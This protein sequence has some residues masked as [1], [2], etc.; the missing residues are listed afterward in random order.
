VLVCPCRYRGTRA[1]HARLAARF[2]RGHSQSGAQSAPR[3]PSLCLA[4][5]QSMRTSLGG[6]HCMQDVMRVWRSH[7]LPERSRL[8]S[9][10]GES[11]VQGAQRQ[12]S[13]KRSKWRHGPARLRR[14][15]LKRSRMSSHEYALSIG[16]CSARFRYAAAIYQSAG[17]LFGMRC[18][19]RELRRARI[20]VG[21]PCGL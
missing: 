13:S 17:E 11:G 21:V 2:L 3:S 12:S 18:S 19:K 5:L 20:R 16:H 7:S 9:N 14:R 10:D 8:R 1:I 4:A 15:T 6:R